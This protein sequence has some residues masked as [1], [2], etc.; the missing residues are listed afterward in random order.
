MLRVPLVFILLAPGARNER[1]IMGNVA[2][3]EELLDSDELDELYKLNASES[4]PEDD[5]EDDEDGEEDG[6]DDGEGIQPEDIPHGERQPL[7]ACGHGITV[8][9]R[10]RLPGKL[11]KAPS[12]GSD[13]N[14]QRRASP[15]KVNCMETVLER[16]GAGLCGLLTVPS[17]SP[18]RHTLSCCLRRLTGAMTGRVGRPIMRPVAGRGLPT[19]TMDRAVIDSIT[20]PRLFRS[21]RARWQA[22]FW[23]E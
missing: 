8:S 3:A 20:P 2:I 9:A 22:C 18:P 11:R 1:I 23:R 14:H 10:A 4:G 6:E 17:E 21:L 7:G 13:V 16:P 12:W 19:G 5:G 15:E